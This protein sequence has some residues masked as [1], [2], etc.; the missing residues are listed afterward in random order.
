MAMFPVADPNLYVSVCVNALEARGVFIVT[1]DP[2]CTDDDDTDGDVARGIVDNVKDFEAVTVPDD[3]AVL[4]EAYILTVLVPSEL[5]GM[6]TSMLYNVWEPEVVLFGF[7][8]S[9][10]K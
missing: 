9:L 7:I 1:A 6:L 2:I 10:L 5:C 8:F 3:V 4:T